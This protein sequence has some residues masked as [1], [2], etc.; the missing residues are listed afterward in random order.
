MVLLTALIAGDWVAHYYVEPILKARVVHTLEARFQ[1]RVELA[2]FQ[3]SVLNGVDA[4]GH[5]LKIFSRGEAGAAPLF[6]V[7][8]FTF[9]IRWIDLLRSPMR[10]RMVNIR[11]LSINLPPK[12]QRWR[13]PRL[14]GYEKKQAGSILV[15]QLE[16]H[17]AELTLNTDKPGRVPLVFNILKL[18]MQRVGPDQPMKFQALLVNPKPVGQ[19]KSHGVFG[20]LDEGAAGDT[21]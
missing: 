12:G 2:G 16:V 18:R 9:H 17:R 20:P 1:S 10:V 11:D 14:K 3:L 19:I 21:P 8:Q 6:A 7:S 15:D 5:G 4:Q 13:M